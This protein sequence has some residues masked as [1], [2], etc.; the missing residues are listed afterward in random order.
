MNENRIAPLLKAQGGGYTAHGFRSSLSDWMAETTNIPH[1]IQER[2]LDHQ[3]REDT[4]V[5]VSYRR[6]DYLDQRREALDAWAAF[7][8]S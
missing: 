6:T 8:T 5:S 3:A 4:A 7:V 2:V 1:I